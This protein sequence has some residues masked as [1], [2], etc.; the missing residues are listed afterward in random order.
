[1]RVHNVLYILIYYQVIWFLK[2]K[3]KD[4]SNYLCCADLS[5]TLT[6]SRGWW[7]RC[8]KKKKSPQGG[9]EGVKKK[10]KKSAPGAPSGGWG[11]NPGPTVCQ[12]RIPSCT[13]RELDSKPFLGFR[14][15]G[16]LCNTTCSVFWRWSL[17]DFWLLG[18]MY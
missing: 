14:R 17:Q 16:R 6:L 12:A 8:K 5:L 11:S 4:L 3:Q 9:R 10:K 18:L 7:G 13:P 1:M 15:V 2:K